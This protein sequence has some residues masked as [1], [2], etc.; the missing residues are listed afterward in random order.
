MGILIIEID[1]HS[2]QVLLTGE[3]CNK[4]QLRQTY[5]RAKE[6]SGDL[7]NLPAIFCRILNYKSIPYD[8]AIPVDFVIDTDTERIY[9]PTY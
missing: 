4:R 5:M 3:K 7:K 1:G 9:S 8:S 2:F 6:L